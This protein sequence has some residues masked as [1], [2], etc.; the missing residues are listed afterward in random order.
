[1]ATPGEKLDE[2]LKILKKLQD[3]GIVAIKTSMLSRVHRERL[4]SNNY[5][6]EVV[7]EGLKGTPVATNMNSK[8]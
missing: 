5:I 2:S 8:V 1:M 4:L 7:K 6:K 3:S